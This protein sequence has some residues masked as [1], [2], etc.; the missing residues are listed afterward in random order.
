MCMQMMHNHIYLRMYSK[1]KWQLL[2]MQNR[3]YFCT[4]LK[5]EMSEN[6]PNSAREINLQY[7]NWIIFQAG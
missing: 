3:N 5:E 7:T 4:S 2:T 1:I 6:L